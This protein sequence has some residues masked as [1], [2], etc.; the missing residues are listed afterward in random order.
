MESV[1][2]WFDNPKPSYYLPTNLDK[3][4]ILFFH[5]QYGTIHYKRTPAVVLNDNACDIAKNL[6]DRGVD[7]ISSSIKRVVLRRL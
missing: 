7:K 5:A 3:L 2:D 4:L 1:I 6:F